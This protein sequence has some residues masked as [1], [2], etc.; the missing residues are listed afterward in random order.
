MEMATP[1]PLTGDRAS[2]AAALDPDLPGP[3]GVGSWADGFQRFLRQRPR[4]LLLGE[5]F[6]LRRARANTY[7]ELRD[8]EGAAPCCIWNSTLDRLALPDGA[9]RDGVE[10]GGVA[11][12]LAG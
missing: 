8:A 5:V 4:V 10:R 12:A 11:R 9:L 1:D 7:F 2:G 3:F 6:N